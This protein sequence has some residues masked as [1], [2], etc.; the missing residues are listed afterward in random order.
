MLQ[1]K[2]STLNL[3]TCAGM[4]FVIRKSSEWNKSIQWHATFPLPKSHFKLEEFT[5][6]LRLQFLYHRLVLNI[7]LLMCR[8]RWHTLL[9]HKHK[10]TVFKIGDWKFYKCFTL[11]FCC[12]FYSKIL[13]EHQYWKQGKQLIGICVYQNYHSLLQLK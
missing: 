6:Y 3:R 10:C 5:C 8:W 7:Y 4:N 1:Y 2:S 9:L 13:A 12:Y 11:E